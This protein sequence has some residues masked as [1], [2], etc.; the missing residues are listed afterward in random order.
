MK[1]IPKFVSIPV[2]ELPPLKEK[3][4]SSEEN[5]SDVNHAFDVAAFIV[6]FLTTFQ[7]WS[8][9]RLDEKSK[10]MNKRLILSFFFVPAVKCVPYFLSKWF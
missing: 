8:S 1:E 5:I 4:K 10:R 2:P 7:D 3:S 6:G 9:P